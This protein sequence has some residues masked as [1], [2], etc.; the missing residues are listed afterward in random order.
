MQPAEWYCENFLFRFHNYFDIKVRDLMRFVAKGAWIIPSI[1]RACI[2]YV[3]RRTGRSHG[4][5]GGGLDVFKL[6]AP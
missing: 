4:R 3:G 6:T 1:L 2:R 5:D